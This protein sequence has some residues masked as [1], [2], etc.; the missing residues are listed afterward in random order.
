MKKHR[1]VENIEIEL[2]GRNVY[3]DLGFADAEDMFV[4]AQLVAKIAELIRHQNLTQQRA[5][6][7]LGLTQPKVSALLRGQFRGISE[8]KLLKCLTTLGR[9][10]QIVVKEAPRRRTAG[11]LS[12]LFA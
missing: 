1:K 7:I 6:Q 9:D 5:A 8:R 12:V 3:A 2:G 11:R 4:K 10:V